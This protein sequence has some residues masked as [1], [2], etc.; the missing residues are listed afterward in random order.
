PS[1]NATGGDNRNP[2][3]SPPETRSPDSTELGAA[4]CAVA[5][6]EGVEGGGELAVG[7][8]AE[9]NNVEFALKGVF[10]AL[11]WLTWG[12]TIVRVWA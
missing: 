9:A 2:P 3:R 6:E 1:T 5:G 8:W 11:R 10:I 7:D 4:H 12:F